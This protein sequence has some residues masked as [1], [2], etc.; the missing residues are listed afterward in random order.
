MSSFDINQCMKDVHKVASQVY[1]QA[2]PH[3]KKALDLIQGKCASCGTDQKKK[4]QA[5]KKKSS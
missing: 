4:S 3:M 5:S 1:E 2:K